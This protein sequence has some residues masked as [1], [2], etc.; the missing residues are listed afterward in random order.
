MQTRRVFAQ[1]VTY[2]VSSRPLLLILDGHS[3]HYQLETIKFAKSNEIILFCLPPHTAH[4]SQPLDTCVFGPLKILEWWCTWFSFKK[5]KKA[6]TKYNFSSIF[7]AAWSNAMTPILFVLGFAIV[8]FIH[9]IETKCSLLLWMAITHQQKMMNKV[10]YNTSIAKI[11]KLAKWKH[12]IFRGV[13][14]KA[15]R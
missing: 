14:W 10:C 15:V 9:L 6:I 11:A 8:V 3:S 4:V 2:A 13:W 12:L 7:R 1:T 5:P